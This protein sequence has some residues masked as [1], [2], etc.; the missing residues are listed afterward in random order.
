MESASWKEGNA[1]KRRKHDVFRVLPVKGSFLFQV[2]GEYGLVSLS[3][4]EDVFL[5]TDFGFPES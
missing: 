1:Q 5:H 2:P 3:H 4:Q